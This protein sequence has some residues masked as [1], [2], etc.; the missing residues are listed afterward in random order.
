MKEMFNELH[1]YDYTDCYRLYKEI[2][3]HPLEY[4]TAGNIN[5][6]LEKNILVIKRKI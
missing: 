6:M 4:T 5:K 2:I 1:I 3:D